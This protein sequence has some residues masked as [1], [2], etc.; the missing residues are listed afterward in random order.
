MRALIRLLDAVL[1]R[2]Y[3]VFEFCDDEDC[4]LRLQVTQV[5]HVLYLD[6]QVVEAGAPVLTI[7]LWNEHVP[8]IPSAG[9]NLAWASRMRRLFIA[10][11]HA[12]AGQVAHDPR[13]A[14]VRAIGGATAL[15]SPVERPGGVHLM[16]RL[17]FTVVPYH[18]PLGCFGEFWE[19]LYSWWIT[20][21]FNAVSLRQ[22]RLLR[23]QRSEIWMSVE[24]F[25]GR[26]GADRARRSE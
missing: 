10:S 13:L 25:L 7:H 24:D 1:R 8:P 20:W 6:G 21:A 11:L 2:A 26:Y 15:F 3:G 9:P 4:L 14:S 17:G 18:R 19:N 12:V 23:L 16:Q 22:R 5:S